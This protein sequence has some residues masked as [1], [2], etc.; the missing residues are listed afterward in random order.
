MRRKVE[1]RTVAARCKAVIDHDRA[2]RQHAA[3]ESLMEEQTRNGTVNLSWPAL[4]AAGERL[5]QAYVR[6]FFF[7][8]PVPK[9]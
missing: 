3:I 9:L 1:Q 4:F 6:L 2:E 8:G 7:G 5:A